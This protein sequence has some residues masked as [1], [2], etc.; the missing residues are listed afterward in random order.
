MILCYIFL[1]KV[2]ILLT[3][4]LISIYVKYIADYSYS[5]RSQENIKLPKPKSECFRKMFVYKGSREHNDLPLTMKLLSNSLKTF[6]K[7]LN[8]RKK[9]KNQFCSDL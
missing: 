8:L 6:F 7:N 3:K 9:K 2:L 4:I 5:L 1:I